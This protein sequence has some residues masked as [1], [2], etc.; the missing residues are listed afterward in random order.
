M[1][2]I[3]L[4][5]LSGALA[6]FL[7]V[8]SALMNKGRRD[9]ELKRR[10]ANADAAKQEAAKKKGLSFKEAANSF[11]ERQ[12]KQARKNKKSQEESTKP[13]S[14]IQRQLDTIDSAL[15]E[16]SFLLVRVVCAVLV[17]LLAFFV[18]SRL[19]LASMYVMLVPLVAAVIGFIVPVYVLG[20]M[21]KARQEEIRLELPDVMDLLVVSVEAGLGFDAAIT[22][23]YESNKSHLMEELMGAIRNVQHGMSRKEAYESIAKKCDVKELTSFTNALLQA[24]QLGISVRSVLTTQAELLRDNRRRRAEER[25]LKAPVTMMIPMVLFIFPVILIVLLA[26]AAVNLMDVFGS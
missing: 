17:A 19:E 24:E 26:P 3:A 14:K 11:K 25:A 22:R 1:P 8:V 21:V 5:C 2:S 12:R 16:T 15:T 13:K 10:L 18:C 4:L 6:V 9:D 23:L 20:S 7:L